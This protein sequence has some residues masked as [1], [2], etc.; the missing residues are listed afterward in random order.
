[1]RIPIKKKKDVTTYKQPSQEAL[2]GQV[3]KEIVDVSKIF[4]TEKE[5]DDLNEKLKKLLE[6]LEPTPNGLIVKGTLKSSNFVRNLKGWGINANLDGDA[7]FTTVVA[8]SYI[9]VFVQ[10]SV[11]TSIHANDIWYDSNDSYKQYYAVIAGATTVAAGQWVAANFPTEW[12]DVQ[13]GASTKPD[14]NADVTSANQAATIASQGALATK[15]TAD[16]STE[17][18]GAEKPA[19]NATVGATFGTDVAGGGAL[20][21]QITNAGYATL[22]RQDKFGDGNDGDATISGNTSLTADVFYNNLTVNT[23]ITLTTAGF[24]LFVKG[25]L[26]LTGTAKVARTGNAGGNGTNAVTTTAGVAGAAGA[27]LADGS[28]IGAV[29]GIIGKVGATGST[30][31]G[32]GNANGTAGT[33]GDAGI[34]VVKSLG[35]TG[36]AGKAGGGGGNATSGAGTGTGAAGG[37]AGTAG[38]KTGT[39]YNQV[40]SLAAAYLLYDIIDGDNLRSSPSSGGAGSGGSGGSSATGGV[41]V[42]TS[43][44][45]GGSGGGGSTGGIVCVFAKTLAGSGTIEAIGGAG[46]DAGT[47]GA[48]GRSNADPHYGVGG[49]SGGSSGGAGGTGGVVIVA[50]ET[51]SGTVTFLATGGAGGTKASGTAANVGGLGGSGTSGTDG[52][53]G[54][55]GATGV[56]IE[57]TT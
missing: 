17:V 27:T 2:G 3:P 47:T 45:S 49:G 20:N 28:I 6:Y 24:R 26:T 32:V 48:S 7:Y 31:N 4:A 37:G 11:P 14:N 42:G 15:N 36:V 10:A 33:A 51:N 54:A 13:D 44:G 57:L 22:F 16:F 5:K 43:G 34:D 41:A 55:T 21:T 18:A 38:A 25:T 50:Y 40:R 8:G 56:V 12:A 29:A 39:I 52:T 30:Q 1:M 35:T 9:Q 23:G 46:G 19:N 53:D